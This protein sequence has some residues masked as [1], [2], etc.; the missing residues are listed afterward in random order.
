MFVSV[1]TCTSATLAA[2]LTLERSARRLG[3]IDRPGGHKTHLSPTPV[4]GGIGIAL[5]LLMTWLASPLLDP[6]SGFVAGA[7]GLVLLGIVDDPL[8]PRGDCRVTSRDATVDGS[9]VA[10]INTIITQ[11]QGDDRA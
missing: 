1:L 3:L 9:L 8:I 10:R 4:V 6:G 7:A 5:G 2:L 11:F